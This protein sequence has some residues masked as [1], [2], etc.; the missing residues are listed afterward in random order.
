[1]TN[2]LVSIFT[3]SHNPV[4]LDDCFNSVI[5]QTYDNWEWIIL[6]NGGVDWTPPFVDGRIKILKESKGGDIGRLKRLACS[7]C[8]GSYFVELDHDDVLA[9]DALEEVVRAFESDP[10]IGVVYSDTAQVDENLKRLD[11]R[12]NS[13]MGWEYEEAIVD[14]VSVLRTKTMHH[15]PSSV[16]YIWFAPNHLRAFRFSTYKMAGGYN[17]DLDILDD[18]DLMSRC[19]QISKFYKIDK[20]LYLQRVHSGNTQKNP[21][22]NNRIQIETVKMYDRTIEANALS[23]A[24]LNDLYAI[25]LGAAHGKPEGYL[26]VDIYKNDD[27]D[28]VA[29][30]SDGLD[31]PDSSVGVIRAADFLEHIPDK[32]GLFN[33]LYRLLAHGGM[34]LTNTPSTDGRG[35]FQDPTHVSF[36]NENSFWYYTNQNYAKY[37]PEI[38][39]KFQLSRIST[40]FPSEWHKKNN[41]CYVNANL[42]A[43]KDGPRI[44]G[45][46]NF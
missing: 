18:Q 35:A 9:S 23:W 36:Y 45:E 24:K 43:V 19:Y 1:M 30:I 34:L 17:P 27:V 25:D 39:C 29:N 26:G 22:K 15:F 32:V 40:Y 21:E 3:P 6:L 2:P 10:E 28:Y 5:N 44:A 14:G 33:E 20:C 31:L 7:Y 46:L 41:I 38:K 12:Y 8:L 4:Y 42:V 16:S 13:A 37:V 11:T